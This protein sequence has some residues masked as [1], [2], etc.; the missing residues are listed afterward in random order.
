LNTQLEQAAQSYAKSMSTQDFF[1]HQGADGSTWQQRI[2]A[3]G[4]HFSDAAENLAIGHP[5]PVRV[6]DAWMNSPGHRRNMLAYQLQEIGVGYYYLR[7]DRG[8]VN[9]NH[10]W[11]KSFGTPASASGS[12]QDPFERTSP[13]RS[14]QEFFNRLDR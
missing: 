14:I 3:T 4:Y 12:T 10:Y 9:A 1:S 5:T 13:S 2:R 8:R 7:H 6:V 11:A